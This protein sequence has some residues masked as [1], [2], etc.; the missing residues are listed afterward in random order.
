M[1]QSP[2]K[3]AHVQFNVTSNETAITTSDTKTTIAAPLLLKQSNLTVARKSPKRRYRVPV[4]SSS[5][6]TESLSSSFKQMAHRSTRGINNWLKL[7]WRFHFKCLTVYTV[8]CRLEMLVSR[9][10]T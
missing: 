1:T 5:S 6:S 10:E 4:A 9:I 7:Y 8:A 2:S 3:N